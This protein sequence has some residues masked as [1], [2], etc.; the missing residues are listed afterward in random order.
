VTTPL[1]WSIGAADAAARLRE[2]SDEL[3]GVLARH[4]VSERSRFAA[5]LV[6]EE[7]V[8]NA[9][10][11]GGARQVVIG[12]D[13]AGDSHRLVFEDDG[14]PFDPAAAPTPAGTSVPDADCSRGR[15][16]VLV[17]G[18]SRAIE[19]G[20]TPRGNRLSILLVG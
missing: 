12:F 6:A 19:H 14:L 9:F 18:F 4:G 1:R 2:A 16:L 7:I 11:H 17:R 20:T 5:R 13:P 8:L 15:G 10:E 3:D